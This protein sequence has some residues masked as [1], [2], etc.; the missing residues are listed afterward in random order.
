MDTALAL[1]A[2][3]GH[4]KVVRL[5]LQHG[6]NSDHQVGLSCLTHDCPVCD[7]VNSFKSLFSVIPSIYRDDSSSFYC[8][9]VDGCQDARGRTALRK[10]IGSGRHSC[11]TLL[12]SAQLEQCCRVA[13]GSLLHL[14][15]S[16]RSLMS[17]LN[18]FRIAKSLSGFFS[19][20]CLARLDRRSASYG[21]LLASCS[22]FLVI[23]FKVYLSHMRTKPGITSS[24]SF[25]FWIVHCAANASQPTDAI[26]GELR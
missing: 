3:R 10:A 25:S 2:D 19:S 23:W 16:R 7:H 5:L 15:S 17:P 14:E 24:S 4:E 8:T 22:L 20:L 21:Q 12:I 1:A 11:V 9:N 6:A 18:Q 26:E 13:V